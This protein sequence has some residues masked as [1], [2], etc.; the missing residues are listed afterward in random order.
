MKNPPPVADIKGDTS[1]DLM[2]NEA[3]KSDENVSPRHRETPEPVPIVKKEDSV[4][5][6]E[7]KEKRDDTS[8]AGVRPRFVNFLGEKLLFLNHLM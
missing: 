4:E 1:P 5:S 8:N 2:N 7:N 6:V 3:P